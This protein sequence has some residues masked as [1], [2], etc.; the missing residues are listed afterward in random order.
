MKL[1]SRRFSRALLLCMATALCIS[2]VFAQVDRVE[3]DIRL[4]SY[5]VLYVTDMF[6]VATGTLSGAIPN[7]SISLTTVPDG[8]VRVV[9]EIVSKIQFRGDA[10]PSDLVNATT[11]PFELNGS[12][13]ISS[14]DLR[15]TGTISIDGSP[16]LVQSTKDRLKRHVENFPTAPVGSYI[17]EVTVKNA[18]NRNAL[19]RQ[20]VTAEVRNTSTAEV[21]LTLIEPLDGTTLLTVLPTFSWT[22]EKPRA[23]LKVFEKLP[24]FQTPEEAVSGLPHI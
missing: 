1:T 4:P 10:G 3:V 13:V 14:R 18:D 24:H 12:L 2:A 16:K 17:L 15:S 20:S 21:T 9:V 19:G 8:S 7:M 22:A 23:R 6:N 11:R 5:D